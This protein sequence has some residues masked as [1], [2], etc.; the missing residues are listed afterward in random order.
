M[1]IED[2]VVFLRVD[3]RARTDESLFNEE[4]EEFQKGRSILLDIPNFGAVTGIPI[5]LMYAISEGAVK[6]LLML[7]ERDI[8][9]KSVAENFTK[10]NGAT[11][12]LS[13]DKNTDLAEKYMKEFVIEFIELYGPKNATTSIG[14][15]FTSSY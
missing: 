2:R 14:T 4:D 12:L 6:R 1:Y 5:H 3:C 9:R 15:R 11:R 13:L 7:W 10:L 8:Y